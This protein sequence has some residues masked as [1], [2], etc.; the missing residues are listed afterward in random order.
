MGCLRAGS[1]FILCA[2]LGGGTPARALTSLEQNEIKKLIHWMPSF[3][4]QEHKP[5]KSCI[6]W[7]REICEAQVEKS[8]SSCQKLHAER[9]KVPGPSMNSWKAK[10]IECTEKDVQRLMK[11]QVV[12][13]THCKN[14]GMQSL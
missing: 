3:A 4:C 14:V 7:T 12:D 10:I 11:T 13:S 2:V 6:L 1:L 5:L 9:I 8:M